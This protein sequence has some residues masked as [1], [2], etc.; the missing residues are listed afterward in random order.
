MIPVEGHRGLYRD[1]ETGAI[2]NYDKN[3]YNKYIALKNQKNNQKKEIENLKNEL[4]EIKDL[5]HKL[6]NEKH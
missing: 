4:S 5:L 1:S 2:V 6:I 3:E